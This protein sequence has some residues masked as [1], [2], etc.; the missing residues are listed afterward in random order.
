MVESQHRDDGDHGLVDAPD[1]LTIGND[2][3]FEVTIVA[4]G[5]SIAS[6]RVPH[7]PGKRE[8][9]LGYPSLSGYT[10]DP[11]Y[12]GATVGRFA[13]RI[14]NAATI[15]ADER[16]DLDANA[17]PHCLHGGSNGLSKQAWNLA[18]S[19]SGDAIVCT[20]RSPHGEQGFPGTVDVAV[21]YRIEGPR[22]LA[23]DFYAE[24]DR[25]TILNLANHAYFNLGDEDTIDDH[26]LLLHAD[27]YTPTDESLIPTG[28][29]EP[30]DDTN[31][32]LREPTPLGGDAPRQLDTNFVVRG[33]TGLLREVALL[34]SRSSGLAMRVETT[35][36]GLQVYTGDYL[37]EPFHP[38]QGVCLEAQNFPDA[39]N[40]SGF[41]SAGLMPGEPYRHT[42]VLTFDS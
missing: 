20:L 17:S 24:T 13:N 27:E 15:I 28:A 10:D 34:A 18:S 36:A 6:L 3:D 19:E 8:V 23:I 42:T 9:I 41:P 35:Q 2:D 38:R 11:Y 30:V 25:E 7:G 37:G 14:A 5:A 40:H 39:P 21:T 4:T 16:I 33:G 12:I 32:D 1:T 22:S 26:T 29:I 31:F